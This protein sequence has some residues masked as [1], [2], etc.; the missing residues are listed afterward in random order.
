MLLL[1]TLVLACRSPA[2]KDAASV[3]E[4]FYGTTRSLRVSGAPS[5]EQL[6]A[7]APY[8]SDS[9]RALLAAAER[10]RDA[11]MARAPDEKPSF[12]EG[13]FFSSLFEGATSVTIV[14]DSLRG[15]THAVTVRMTSNAAQPATT[16]TDVAILVAQGGRWVI[17]DIVYGGQW[18]FAAKGALRTALQNGL[19]SH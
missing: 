3:V 15:S 10:L 17:D 14:T 8:L 6:T 12:A 11:D 16:W 19:Q 13:D 5:P 9:L 2:D 7:L 4:R 1:A 18:A